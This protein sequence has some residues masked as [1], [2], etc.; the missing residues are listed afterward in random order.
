MALHST[1]P[2]KVHLSGAGS[3]NSG[4]KSWWARWKDRVGKRAH[5]TLMKE[6]DLDHLGALHEAAL[7]AKRR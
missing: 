1:V 7:H 4:R 2:W 5:P 6:Q 3:G